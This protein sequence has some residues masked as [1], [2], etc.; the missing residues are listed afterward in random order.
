MVVDALSAPEG[1]E[2]AREAEAA[3]LLKQ[4]EA[5]A[6]EHAYVALCSIFKNEHGTERI[7]GTLSRQVALSSSAGGVEG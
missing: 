4:Y 2:G 5:Q 7:E 3:K 1:E 6:Q